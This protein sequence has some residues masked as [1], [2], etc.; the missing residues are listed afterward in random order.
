MRV[1]LIAAGVAAFG[2]AVVLLVAAMSAP[3]SLPNGANQWTTSAYVPTADGLELHLS[4]GG[5]SFAPGQSVNLTVW[6]YNPSSS[7][8]DVPVSPLWAVGGLG[9]GPC[10]ALNYAMGFEIL[11]G[12]YT[13]GDVKDGQGLQLY[14]PGPYACPMVLS[15]ITSYD[16]APNSSSASVYGSC[17][18]SFCFS[19]AQSASGSFSGYYGLFGH[20]AF[21]PGVYTVVGGDVWGALVVLHFSVS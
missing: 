19:E 9:V 3:L 7:E 10:G 17:S 13:V 5:T 20:E 21:P 14:E 16:F 12:N 8:V 11:S 1:E 15:G 2:T 6:L 4:I 18:G